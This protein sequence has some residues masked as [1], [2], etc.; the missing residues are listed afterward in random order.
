[1][2]QGTVKDFDERERTGT[3]LMEDRTEVHIDATSVEGSG[4]RFLRMGQRV[5]FDLVEEGGRKLARTLRIVTL[6]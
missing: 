6:D 4:L 2:A 1:M 5:R 3:L